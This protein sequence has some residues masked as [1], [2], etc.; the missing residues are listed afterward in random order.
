MSEFAVKRQGKG[1]KKMTISR[2]LQIHTLHFH[3][4]ALLERNDN[5]LTKQMVY[6]GAV[7]TRI[8]Q[9]WLR[10]NWR[11]AEGGYSLLGLGGVT[12]RPE[13]D[14]EDAIFVIDAFTVHAEEGG[15]GYFAAV[16]D[17]HRG[18]GSA[19]AAH[20]GDTEPAGGLF[21]GCVVVDAAELVSILEGCARRDWQDAD[22]TLASRVVEN[23]LHLVAKVPPGLNPGATHPHGHASLMLVEV[24]DL[25]PWTLSQAFR[26]PALP[27]VADAATHL[28]DHLGR[29]D[30]TH[31]RDGVRRVMSVEEWDIPGADRLSLDDLAAW[32]AQVVRDGETGS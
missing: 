23:L 17:L 20:I 28:S 1:R 30:S 5:G 14:I 18:D 32:A 31:S 16:D 3:P 25:Q 21:Y 9:H 8:S 12:S 4:A 29:M 24:G 13:A 6:G 27:T 19:G 7:R 2:F 22:R 15:I 11:V 10:R 26:D